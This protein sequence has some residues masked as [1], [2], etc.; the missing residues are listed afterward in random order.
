M[1]KVR[2]KE[3]QSENVYNATL[4]R[5]HYIYDRFDKVVVSFSGGKDSTAVLNTALAVARE[6]G[7]LP[8][9]VVF[10]DEEAIHPPTI[11]YVHRV[12]ANKEI[13]LKW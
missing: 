13:D 7:K 5:I 9:E 10:F 4:K 2:K 8:L 1:V 12:A 3:Y 11:G 6:R